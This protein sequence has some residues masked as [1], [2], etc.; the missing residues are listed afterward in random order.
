MKDKSWN[1]KVITQRCTEGG[2]SVLIC[3]ICGEKSEDRRKRS[4]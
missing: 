2:K 3:D 4:V 1:T